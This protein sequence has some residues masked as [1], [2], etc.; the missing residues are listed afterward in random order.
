MTTANT[1]INKITTGL[2]C[3][4]GIIDSA[5]EIAPGITWVT[6][7][8]HGGFILS[9]ARLAEMPANLRK[10]SFTQN[11]HF[12]EDCSWCAVPL[13]F[14]SLFPDNVVANARECYAHSYG[15]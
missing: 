10:C 2:T 8:S 15:R 12:E 4:W 3:G 1:N 7:A 11:D 6:T 14:P 5:R 13:A 9:P